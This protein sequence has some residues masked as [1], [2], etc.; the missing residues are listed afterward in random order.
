MTS[1]TLIADLDGLNRACADVCRAACRER[2]ALE[3][4]LATRLA[5]IASDMRASRDNMSRVREAFAAMI[6]GVR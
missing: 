2:A 6:G 3:G 1:P 5:G 4:E